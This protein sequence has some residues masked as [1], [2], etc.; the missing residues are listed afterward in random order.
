MNRLR[1]V[2]VAALVLPTLVSLLACSGILG[3]LKAEGDKAKAEAATWAVGKDQAACVDEAMTRMQQKGQLDL[4]YQ[5]LNTVWLEG[6]LAAA[7]PIAGFCDGVPAS[8]ETTP[9]VQ[10][11]AGACAARGFTDAG[12]LRCHRLLNGVQAFC[13]PKK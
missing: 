2:L 7:T 10:W 6:C 8:G 4:S 5:S 3:D 13:H 1:P 9:T 11:A 12:D